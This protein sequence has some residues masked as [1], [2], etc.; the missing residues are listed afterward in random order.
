MIAPGNAAA[1]G[2]RI[3]LDPLIAEAKRRARRRRVLLGLVLVAAG[4]G[5][6]TWRLAT[7]QPPP[8]R[9]AEEMR[10]AAAAGQTHI[11]ESG[12]TGGVGW[13]IADIG[14]WITTDGGSRW[15]NATP[16]HVRA[17]DPVARINQIQFVDREHGWLSAGDVYG[18]FRIPRGSASVRHMEIDRTSDGGRTWQA[19]VPPG[20][21]MRCGDNHVDFLDAQHGFMLGSGG[22][23]STADG[24]ATWT[25][26]APAP[27]TGQ[28]AF[29]DA[30]IGLGVSDP[31]PLGGGRLYRTVDGGRSWTRLR[32]RGKADSIT[33]FGREG[34]V[35]VRIR[36]A[37]GQELV[38]HVTD[39]AGATWTTRTAPF[40]LHLQWGVPLG[41]FSAASPDV[42]FAAGRRVLYETTDAG[43]SW[44]AIRPLDLPPRGWIWQA[45]FTSADDG[46]AVFWLP[47]GGRSSA[48]AL[49]RTTDGGRDWTPLEPPVPK[50][51]PLPKQKPACG[52]S[53]RRP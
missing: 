45:Q 18:G 4:S 53:C 9:A 39:D 14:L 46:W 28:F 35:P 5:V 50:P 42:W 48:G 13:A 11:V 44:R 7:S 51:P 20:C 30:R 21:L 33:V 27:F 10:I 2:W 6:A 41:Y 36:T 32:I 31:V 1:R 8:S 40:R 17:A 22:L 12:L 25:H 37:H 49:V 24:G 52:S 38:V 3:V 47:E 16:K 15:I 26:V 23:F 19:S 43:L 34:I 29:V